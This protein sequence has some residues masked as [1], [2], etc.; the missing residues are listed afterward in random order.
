MSKFK[1]GD[2]VKIIDAGNSYS[3]FSSMA[4]KL[5][6]LSNG[7]AYRWEHGFASP[8]YLKMTGMIGEIVALY[9]IYALVNLDFN[10][11]K[12]S[13]IFRNSE[14]TL[15]LEEKEKFTFEEV[16]ARI[17]EGE[18]YQN[19]LS[20]ISKIDGCIEVVS[21]NRS[22]R[23]VPKGEEYI[24]RFE[25]NNYKL[26]PQKNNY[27][28]FEVEHQEGGKRYLFRSD[29]NYNL[30]DIVICQTSLGKSY[31]KIVYKVIKELTEEEFKAY[32]PIIKSV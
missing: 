2:K 19:S 26:V 18:V 25:T 15:L 5:T 3:K 17:K 10:G 28:L 1:V 27:L 16:I 6:S 30:G 11:I 29:C 8:D 31:G 9:D 14:T 20:S 4:D 13:I 22:G 21:I 32:K 7:K 23:T 12:R 24:V